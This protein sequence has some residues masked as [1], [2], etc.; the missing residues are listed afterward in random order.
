MPMG[1]PDLKPEFNININFRSFTPNFRSQYGYNFGE[2]SA[3]NNEYGLYSG[4]KY[5]GIKNILMS[6]Y[7]DFYASYARTYYVPEPIHGI[8]LFFQTDWKI[9]KTS[10]ALIRLCSENKTDVI[11]INDTGKVVYQ[12]EIY[13]VRTEFENQLLKS[14][15]LRIRLEA[16]LIGFEKLVNEETGIAGFVEFKWEP[17][18][19]LQTG[20]RFSAF[21]TNSFESVI[22]QYE[23]AMPGYMT[24]V[25]LYGDGFRYLAFLKITP[26]NNMDLWF[27]YSITKKNNVA[28]LS[29]G[30]LEILGNRDQRLM[31]QLDF[32]L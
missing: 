6:A 18:D 14:L 10:K 9:D 21:S 12:K 26:I 11:N 19:F 24:T 4:L 17:F 25:P 1:M 16:N 15:S 22:Y 32:R 5:K 29:S 13:R 30:Y 23:M 27:R 8:D 31:I 7:A 3:P 2:S 20:F 28:S